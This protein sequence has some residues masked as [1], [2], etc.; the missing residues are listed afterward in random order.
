MASSLVGAGLPCLSPQ[1]RLLGSCHW[2]C[3]GFL[4]VQRKSALLLFWENGWGSPAKA[5]RGQRDPGPESSEPPYLSFP[6]LCLA[7][8]GPRTYLQGAHQI[9]LR[10]ERRCMPLKRTPHFLQLRGVSSTAGM[11]KASWRRWGCRWGSRGFRGLEKRQEVQVGGQT[12]LPGRRVARIPGWVWS[13]RGHGA[14][15]Q[16]P[17]LGTK[18]TFPND[19]CLPGHQDSC[20]CG[21][22]LATAWVQTLPSLLPN[23]VFLNSLAH[24]S[25]IFNHKMELIA[26]YPV[27][28]P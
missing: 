20:L 2:L 28:S 4:S 17:S 10:N 27:T 9:P 3:L 1:W 5:S 18:C 24:L 15:E 14:C 25:L 22:A 26:I 11:W 16:R 7:S 21:K 13:S 6:S 23:H 19:P 12:G 8:R